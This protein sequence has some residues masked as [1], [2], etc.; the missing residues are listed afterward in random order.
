MFNL[1]GRLPNFLQK[2]P[3][4]SKWARHRGDVGNSTGFISGS[5][6]FRSSGVLDLADE[7][8]ILGQQILSRWRPHSWTNSPEDL[9]IPPWKISPLANINLTDLTLTELTSTE[10]TFVDLT[11][12][13][14][15]ST[16]F[17][18]ANLTSTKLTSVD[19]TLADLI[20]AELTVI[21]LSSTKLASRNSPWR[22]S[23]QWIAPWQI[24]S[25]RF[26][27]W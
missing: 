2:V 6:K 16:D 11:L 3:V 17:T 18:F 5:E 24:S 22:I 13:E 15:T 25:R 12:A 20:S 4:F 26:P 23:P 9:E 1:Q 8:L 14:L 19:L 7:G 21:D 27:S 10:L